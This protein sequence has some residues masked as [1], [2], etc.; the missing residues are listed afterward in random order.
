MTN[1]RSLSN[2]NKQNTSNLRGKEVEEKIQNYLEKKFRT[3][4]SFSTKHAYKNGLKKFFEFLE[5]KFRLDII[6]LLTQIKESKKLDPLDVLDEY[7]SFLSNYKKRLSNSTIRL[8]I[9]IAKDFLNSEG[10]KIYSEDLKHKFRLPR[11]TE[12]YEKGLSKQTINRIVRLSN[13]KLACVILM[14]CASGMR[15]AEVVQLRLSDID[16]NTSPTTVRIRAETTKTRQTRI[17]CLS[18]EATNALKDLLAKTR[19][20]DYI[21]LKTHEEKISEIKNRL[22][23]NK[24]EKPIFK[25]KDKKRL[26]IL[27]SELSKLSKEELYSKCV[28]TIRHSFEN[29]L[30]KVIENIPELSEKNENGR[31]S[32]H[33]HAFRAWFKTQVTDA[34]ESDFAEALMG[35]KSLKLVY[36][37]QSE[38]ARSQTYLKIEHAL[39]IADTEKIDREYSELQKDNL[40]LRGIVDSFSKELRSLEKRIMSV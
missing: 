13:P 7:Y 30:V 33:F 35:H 39:T 10:C 37:R 28:V 15:I 2:K 23:Q 1:T 32:I 19:Q 5:A 24:Y 21:F 18:S 22:Q 29:Q 6:D 4:R 17:T 3:S 16:F 38:K 36:Y 20:S 31:N 8:Y 25:E 26:E 34:H 40:E 12:V 11:R 27:E 14:I 9:V